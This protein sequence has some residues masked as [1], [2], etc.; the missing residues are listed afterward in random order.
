MHLH[1]QAIKTPGNNQSV[2]TW[3]LFLVMALCLYDSWFAEIFMHQSEPFIMICIMGFAKSL[4]H[5]WCA[6]L[7]DQLTDITV[8]GILYILK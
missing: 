6:F 8:D 4:G 7:V 1:E 5:K 2:L 3:T